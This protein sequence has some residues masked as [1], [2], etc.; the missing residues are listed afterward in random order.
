LLDVHTARAPRL[1]VV[2]GPAGVGKTRLVEVIANRAVEAGAAKL[3]RANFAPGEPGLQTLVA[4]ACGLRGVDAA[5]AHAVADAWL[6]RWL[7]DVDLTADELCALAGRGDSVFH[8]AEER[9]SALVRL[10]QA[11]ARER[12][13]LVW[14]DEAQ[15]SREAL[16]LVKR[17]LAD[18]P[19]LPVLFVVVTPAEG[20]DDE[21]ASDSVAAAVLHELRQRPTTTTLELRPL[22]DVAHGALCTELLLG[23]AQGLASALRRRTEG[24]ALLAVQIVGDWVRRGLV[25]AGPEGLVPR[26]GVDGPEN[27]LAMLPEALSELWDS[28]IDSAL[29]D[30]RFAAPAR[31]AAALRALA[32]AAVLGSDVDLVEWDAVAA[33]AG[34]PSALLDDVTD[35]IV[36]AGLAHRTTRGV[37]FVHA[38]VRGALEGRLRD[39]GVL[40]SLHALAARALASLWGTD[41]AVAAARIGRHLLAAGDAQGALEPLLKAATA[42]VAEGNALEAQTLLTEWQEARVSAGDDDV[43]SFGVALVLAGQ[44]AHQ[45]GRHE[46]A[47]AL[48]TQAARICRDAKLR[49]QAL[50]TAASANLVL[51]AWDVARGAFEGARVASEQAHDRAGTA[52]ALRGLGDV[53]YYRGDFAAA[54]ARYE[55]AALLLADMGSTSELAKT[56]WS[57]GYVE[58]ERGHLDGA[59][60]LFRE[61]RNLARAARDRLNEANAENAL[62]EL[63]RRRNRLDEAERRYRTATRIAQASGLSRRWVFRTNLA[64]VRLLRGDLAGAA[65]DAREVL[66]SRA[67]HE[68][69]LATGA[70]FIVALDALAR[71]D[72][73]TWTRAI[74]EGLAIAATGVVEADLVALALRL[75]D[76]MADR[77]PVR[78]S[79][80]RS[81]VHVSQPALPTS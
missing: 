43:A 7:P 46:E 65:L 42:A 48:S 56:L 71:R 24:N 59:Q 73:S 9:E 28:R 77:D 2:R 20:P 62:G 35:A 52:A 5:R 17:V 78:A 3:L 63:A 1:V 64:Y 40:P 50:R 70:S 32:L 22:D 47:Q 4:R 69:L 31:A 19:E 54:A 33:I 67:A 39:S 13:L 75:I 12:P 79:R 38:M 18:A 44:V 61:Q 51:G 34:L 45:E 49:A 36:S 37:R 57:S 26:M 74:D 11:F 41:T 10:L 14:L 81:F 27:L 29:H 21:D 68:P 60:R 25:Q 58:L 23:P 30:E 53:D 76:A 15:R 66:A 8:G 72:T 80:L 16:A 55:S 6:S